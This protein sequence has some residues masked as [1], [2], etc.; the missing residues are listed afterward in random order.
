MFPGLSSRLEKDIREQYCSVILKGE[1]NHIAKSINVI[2]RMRGGVEG[3]RS[4]IG[5]IRCLRERRCMRSISRI[6]WMRGFQGRNGKNA[7]RA[8]WKSR[9]G[10]DECILR[11]LLILYIYW[12][13]W[14]EEGEKMKI[15]FGKTN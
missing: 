7:E 9:N 14:G 4:R 6:T 12:I 13:G 8:S 15:G 2:V 10:D 11:C 3:R 1:T 5:S